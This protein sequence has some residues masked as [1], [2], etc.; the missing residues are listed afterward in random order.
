[1][2]KE[3]EDTTLSDLSPD[4]RKARKHNPRNVGMITDALR[5]VGAARSGVIDENNE[6]LAGNA[7][8]EALAEVG[9]ERVKIVEAEGDEWVV[10]RRRGLSPEQK[11]KLALYDNRTAELAEWDA[12]SIF[13]DVQG[14]M[15]LSAMWTE[16]EMK[17]VFAEVEVPE[18]NK[19]IDE[20]ALA[21]TENECPK[22]GFKW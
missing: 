3:P 15:D 19:P 5:E 4:P 16:A 22:C 21:E 2:P 20:E 12:G 6:I 11:R 14:G 7:T 9:I 17:E 18:E 13:E 8:A 1:M 10:V